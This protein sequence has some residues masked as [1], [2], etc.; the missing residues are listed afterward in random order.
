MAHQTVSK[1]DI[2]QLCRTIQITTPDEVR[3][4]RG[5]DGIYLR[6]KTWW[7]RYSFRGK[8]RRESSGSC[9]PA[10]AQK[11]LDRRMVRWRN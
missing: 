6:G 4:E 10:L 2:D 11:R 1:P 3:R 5:D 9:D 7:I 8:P